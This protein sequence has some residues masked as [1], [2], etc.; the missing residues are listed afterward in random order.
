MLC[1]T[2]YMSKQDNFLQ[3]KKNLLCTPMQINSAIKLTCF[4]D[5]KV[6]NPFVLAM[7]V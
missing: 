2:T 4:E 5:K 7:I 1:G 6:T 3:R